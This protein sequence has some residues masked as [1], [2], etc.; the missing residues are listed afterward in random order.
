[1][2]YKPKTCNLSSRARVHLRMPVI[3]ER[4]SGLPSTVGPPKSISMNCTGAWLM[5]GMRSRFGELMRTVLLVPLTEE[6][7][8]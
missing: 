6:P 2:R 4:S 1:M 8:S 3:V 7:A 5:R